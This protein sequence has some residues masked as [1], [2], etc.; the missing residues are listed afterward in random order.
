MDREFK[1]IT[2]E[3]VVEL[4]RGAYPPNRL[5]IQLD[6]AENQERKFGISGYDS[7]GNP[8]TEISKGLVINY[9]GTTYFVSQADI[10]AY[11]E[12][13]DR[14]KRPMTLEQE[15][16]YLKAKLRELEE[17]HTKKTIKKAPVRT[18][19]ASK[20]KKEESKEEPKT[21]PQAVEVP[22]AKIPERDLTIP[23]P[24]GQPEEFTTEDLKET[25]AKEIH[26]QKT[27]SEKVQASALKKAEEKQE[28]RDRLTESS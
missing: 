12:T 2:A 3:E 10:A 17:K 18:E 8:I 7:M 5:L 6:E 23:I 26:E 9:A 28:K 14:P 24:K 20:A 13:H 4:L 22:E 25:F 11:F 27:P 16:A 15:N 21:P 19:T 1:Q